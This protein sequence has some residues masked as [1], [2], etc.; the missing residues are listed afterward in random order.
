MLVNRVP[1]LPSSIQSSFGLHHS[2]PPTAFRLVHPFLHSLP[3][4]LAQTRSH[5]HTDHACD[6]CRKRPQ[7]R[8]GCGRCGPVTIRISSARRAASAS[9]LRRNSPVHV[10]RMFAVLS[11]L[12]SVWAVMTPHDARRV[13]PNCCCWCCCWLCC[14]ITVVLAC[15]ALTCCAD[16]RDDA[17]TPDHWTAQKNVATC[18]RCGGIIVMSLLHIC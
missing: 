6:M 11:A 12:L 15:P 4:C 8:T 1:G 5:R 10:R 3:A 18:S 2:A 16:A 9:P 17:I 13:Y 7:L 14:L